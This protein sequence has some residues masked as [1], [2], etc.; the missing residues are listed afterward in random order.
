MVR[1]NVVVKI[2]TGLHAR[3]AANLVKLANTFN[4]SVILIKE[5]KEINAKDIWDVL[6]GGVESGDNLTIVCDGE[7]DSLAIEQVYAFINSEEES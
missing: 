3:P 4:C 1:K 2:L 7:D 5:N 6:N